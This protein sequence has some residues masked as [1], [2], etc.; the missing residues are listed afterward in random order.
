MA[1]ASDPDAAGRA[2]AVAQVRREFADG[3]AARLE[4]M[5]AALDQLARGYDQEV[6]ESLYRR[7]HSLKGTA[8]SF[9][10]DDL[11]AHAAPL[12]DLGAG[13][14]HARA[15]TPDA[16]ASA[17]ELLERLGAAAAQYRSAHPSEDT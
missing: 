2:A 14:T 13:W 6:A 16:V 3:L 7:A 10:A 17:S 5:R 15:V 9:G 8:A 4:A 11:A 1:N 12:A